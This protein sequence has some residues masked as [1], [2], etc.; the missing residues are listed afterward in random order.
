MHN[1]FKTV[2]SQFYLMNGDKQD[3]TLLFDSDGTVKD[4]QIKRLFECKIQY[5]Y[6]SHNGLIK[7]MNNRPYYHT[8]IHKGKYNI[9]FNEVANI[10]PPFTRCFIGTFSD[11]GMQHKIASIKVGEY[12]KAFLYDPDNNQLV[13]HVQ[14][15]MNKV[16]K[17]TFVVLKID[18]DGY[19]KPV[20]V[21][22]FTVP[23]RSGHFYTYFQTSSNVVNDAITAKE[24]FL[25]AYPAILTENNGDNLSPQQLD[26]QT[27]YN[28]L[29]YTNGRIETIPMQLLK[30]E[31]VKADIG[32]KEL[33]SNGF[34]STEYKLFK[35]YDSKNNRLLRG[36]KINLG[37]PRDPATKIAKDNMVFFENGIMPRGIT[38]NK[39]KDQLAESY[40]SFKLYRKFLAKQQVYAYDI[41]RKGQSIGKFMLGDVRDTNKFLLCPRAVM[42]K[43]GNRFYI[44]ELFHTKRS[45][46]NTKDIPETIIVR[47]TVV[48]LNK[49][50]NADVISSEYMLS[51]NACKD[52]YSTATD[53]DFA[54][55]ISRP[56]KIK[57]YS[58][59]IFRINNHLFVKEKIVNGKDTGR[60][61]VLLNHSSFASQLAGNGYM[62][63]EIDK[64]I[65]A[66]NLKKKETV[67]I[68]QSNYIKEAFIMSDIKNKDVFVVLYESKDN[69]KNGLLSLKRIR[70]TN[71]NKLLVEDVA[72]KN[73]SDA[74]IENIKAYNYGIC[75]AYNNDKYFAVFGRYR[76]RVAVR[77]ESLLLYDKQTKSLVNVAYN[78]NNILFADDK[79]IAYWLGNK[80]KSIKKARY[81]T[82]DIE[83]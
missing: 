48:R 28:I 20:Q 70:S 60:V 12:T 1:D 81:K 30:D 53:V 61:F 6:F 68:T 58:D 47:R 14:A 18:D 69:S 50:R 72:T 77:Y 33:Y 42:R 52:D 44:Y 49:D 73:V 54:Q 66:Y 64:N 55:P 8:I 7:T 32:E 35:Y 9:V 15:W 16:T 51:T 80:G 67:K 79:Q 78:G 82:Y 21:V 40:K 27:R 13:I 31:Q 39:E 56:A 3:H 63:F 26:K 11:T 2:L 22:R 5:V 19:F 45:I 75:V 74:V 24:G 36:Y 46:D 17:R 65:Y 34:F 76:S 10:I 59:D 4:T 83:R 57:M 23:K 37:E 25:A 43:K 41:T 38:Y 62:I 29:A 71:E